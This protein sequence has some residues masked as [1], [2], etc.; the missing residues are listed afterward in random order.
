MYILHIDTAD[1]LRAADVP[2]KN[3]LEFNFT[4]NEGLTLV[5]GNILKIS[6]GTTFDR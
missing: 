5:D 6:L 1:N 3:G 2:I 4:Q